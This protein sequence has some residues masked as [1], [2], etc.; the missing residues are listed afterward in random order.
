MTDQKTAI[1]RVQL[2]LAIGAVAAY[3]IYFYSLD[4]PNSGSAGSRV[5]RLLMWQIAAGWTDLT[6]PAFE[7]IARV[8]DLGAIRQ[9]GATLGYAA[10]IV[11]AAVG[12]G[13]LV[14]RLGGLA[15]AES[16]LPDALPDRRWR[17]AERLVLAF[18][19]GAGVVSLATLAIGLA[20][21]MNRTTVLVT[22]V[23]A[24]LAALAE[25][26]DWVRRYLRDF[27][28]T[29]RGSP[30]AAFAL[31]L[32]GA[33]AGLFLVISLFGAALPA[34]DF[35]VRAYHLQG[36][37]EFYL[38]GRIEFLPHN[39]YTSMPF[40]T[41]M[42]SLVG[43]IVAG[44][45]WWGALVGQVV[46]ATFAPMTALGVL[47]IGRRLF[48]PAAGWLAALVYLTTPW[49]YRISIIPYTENALCFYLLAS[50]LALVLAVQ[51]ADGSRRV[52]L[53]LVAGLLAGVAAACKYTA[54]TSTVLPMGLAAVAC[55]W[56]RRDR[57]TG[58]WRLR[59]CMYPALALVLGVIVSFGPW[60]AKNAA[61]TGNP[62]YPLFFDILGGRNW[63]AE[64]NAR[65]EWGHRVPLFVRLGLTQ[66][67][68]GRVAGRED[69]Q[70]GITPRLLRQN[71][72]DV[73]AQADW[74]SPLLFGLAP[75]ALLCRGG[76]RA[77]GWLWLAV[78]FLFFQ[79][80]LLTHRIDR[81]WV[82]LI[83]LVAVLAGAGATWT[84]DRGWQ[85]FIAA[86]FAATVFFNFSYCT[87]GLC[88]DNRYN[89]DLVRGR[90]PS[91]AAVNW[92]NEHL[93]SNARVLAVGA[94][95]LFHL[96][97]TVVYNTVF[98]NCIF[99]QLVRDQPPADAAR[100]LGERATHVYVNWTEIE[101]YRGTYGYTDYVT[102]RVFRDLVVAGVLRPLWKQP[103]VATDTKNIAGRALYVVGP[104]PANN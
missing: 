17:A 64:K 10:L 44:D 89:A 97:R 78:V 102:P 47:A 30:A 94:A 59:D 14:L 28:A 55:P 63:T 74:L 96:D 51:Q 24:A 103:S 21:F 83:P 77:A 60:L 23:F 18:G 35:D 38:A 66:P 86:V 98:D 76:R 36:P 13:R 81:F 71:F 29:P 34:T 100:R 50:V 73:T 72:I 41:E 2:A 70:H 68:A 32:G 26:G 40:G 43:M 75:L 6:P 11:L 48:S 9:R 91:D 99:E 57:A 19:I 25:L 27:R 88:G 84:A 54:L 53:W 46:L 5:S 95:D 49:V 56:L 52:R 87:T 8:T 37:K 90:D 85:R 101:R 58:P 22:L 69:H 45:W 39:V 15:G 104:D 42:L 80:W 7:A 3:L 16:D 61:V 12:W 79:W 82:P 93:P 20:G 67:P 65:W 92:M 33:A 1:H 62:V 31:G 4:L